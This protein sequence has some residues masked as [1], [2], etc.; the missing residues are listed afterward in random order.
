[1]VNGL[2]YTINTDKKR[3][4]NKKTPLNKEDG[5]IYIIKKEKKTNITN[6]PN[7]IQPED[8]IRNRAE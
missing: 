4:I 6:H 5:A 2:Q 3:T 7:K 1:V 8:V